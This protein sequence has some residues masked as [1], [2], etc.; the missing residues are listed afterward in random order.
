[1]SCKGDKFDV[2]LSSRDLKGERSTDGKLS[3][4]ILSIMGW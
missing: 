2:I 3:Y 4:L 1:M